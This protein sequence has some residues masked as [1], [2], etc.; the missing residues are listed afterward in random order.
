MVRAGS[1]CTISSDT[2]SKASFTNMGGLVLARPRMANGHTT[3]RQWLSISCHTLGV[4]DATAIVGKLDG[5]TG[6]R[7]SR[8]I[9]CGV[10]RPP[11]LWCGARVPSCVLR[12]LWCGGF[13]LF[14]PLRPPV[15]WWWVLG[16]LNPLWCGVVCCCGRLVWWWVWVV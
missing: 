8:L 2:V 9:W 1:G 16:Y 13:G 14:N 4:A 5:Y 11:F 12:R 6:S 7:W 15:V 3:H 10:G